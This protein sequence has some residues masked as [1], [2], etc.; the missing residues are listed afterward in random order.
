MARTVEIDESEFIELLLER[1]YSDYNNYYDDEVWNA[2]F[3]FLSES[4]WLEPSRN[5]PSYIVDN[6]AVNGDIVAKEDLPREYGKSFE[7]M[8]EDE[9]LF[10]TD[11]YVIFNMGV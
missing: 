4:G 9:Y 5:N 6:I 3:E 2:C 1:V 7:E 11:N 10:A 8:D